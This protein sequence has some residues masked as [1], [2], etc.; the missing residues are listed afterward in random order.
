[1]PEPVRSLELG[2]YASQP[3]NVWVR[4]VHTVER[5]RARLEARMFTDDDDIV[6]LVRKVTSHPTPA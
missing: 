3:E 2:L 5:S 6:L 4:P 1:M